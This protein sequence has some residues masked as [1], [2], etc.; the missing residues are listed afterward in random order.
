LGSRLFA[1]PAKPEG[2]L[3]ESARTKGAKRLA[4][5]D[6]RV[7]CPDISWST[8]KRLPTDPAILTALLEADVDV[9]E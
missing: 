8:G 2:I 6:G 7:Q 3:Y 1:H 4:L 9:L 5:F